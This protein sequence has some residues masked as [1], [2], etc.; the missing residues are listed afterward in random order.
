[1]NIVVLIT[2]GSEEEAVSIGRALV[3]ERLAAC[4]N[5]VP[6]IRSIYRWEGKVQDDPEALMIVKTR[7]DL[8]E[9]LKQ[10]VLELHPYSVPEVIS[11]KIEQGH[12]EYLAW[13]EDS[14]GKE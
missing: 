8:F 7:A 12:E 4:A 10:R 2:A 13:L 14:T 5:I 1:M 6:R 3:E 11:L 9:P